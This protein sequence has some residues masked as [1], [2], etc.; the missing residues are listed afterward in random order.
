[1]ANILSFGELSKQYRITYD[2]KL[3]DC[4]YCHTQTEVVEFHR[5][6]ESLYS[7]SLPSGYKKEVREYDN[8]GHSQVTTTTENRNNYTTGQFQ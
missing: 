2:S 6:L 1:M 5:T 8:M 4:F 7:M 3:A